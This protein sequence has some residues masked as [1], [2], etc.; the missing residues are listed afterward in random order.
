MLG[1][2]GRLRGLCGRDNVEDL[3]GFE[4]LLYYNIEDFDVEPLTSRSVYKKG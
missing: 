3:C 1:S 4:S 2:S